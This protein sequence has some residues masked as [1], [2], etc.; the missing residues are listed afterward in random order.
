M[1]VSVGVSV[2]GRAET[3]REQHLSSG[4]R[5]KVGLGATGHTRCRVLNIFA[6]THHSDVLFD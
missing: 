2:A 1:R 6:C 3:C 5:V 4:S